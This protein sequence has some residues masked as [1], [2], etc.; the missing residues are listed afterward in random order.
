MVHK[1]FNDGRWKGLSLRDDSDIVGRLIERAPLDLEQTVLEGCTD[2]RWF[3]KNED[4]YLGIVALDEQYHNK[5]TLVNGIIIN[6][7]GL[8]DNSR[9]SL[10]NLDF[11]KFGEFKGK[12][13]KK[14]ALKYVSELKEE[15]ECK[16]FPLDV[17]LVM[18]LY[19]EIPLLGLLSYNNNT[20]Y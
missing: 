15:I 11:F 5:W 6:T 7:N 19:P 4:G 14:E 1:L 16:R 10:E 3:I 9:A 20:S 12:D 13:S 17:P 2:D 18:I 8:A